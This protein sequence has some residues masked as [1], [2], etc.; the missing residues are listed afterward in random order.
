MSKISIKSPRPTPF[1]LP[2]KKQL[3]VLL[4]GS[5][6]VGQVF[7]LYLIEA[8]VELGF[9]ARPAS[10]DKLKQ[11]L[12]HG[13]IPLFQTSYFRR[14]DP[15][16]HRLENYQVVTDVAESQRFK[17]HQIW[18]TTPSPVY[19]SEW[20]REFLQK[21]PSERVVCFAPEG[22]RS[23]FFPESG[24]EDRLVF[25]GITFISWQ[26]D[27]EGG[28]GRPEGV[29]FWLPPLLGIPL[30]GTEKACREV[31][32]LLKIAGFRVMVKKQDFHKTLASVTAVML[33]FVAGLELSGWS[34]RAF[35][36]SPWLKRAACGSREAVLSQLTGTGIFTRTLLRILFS[37]TGFF[38]ATL[39]LPFLFPFDLEK[40]LKFHYLKTRDQTLTLLDVFARDGKRRGLPVENIQVLLQGLLDSA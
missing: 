15:V 32:E 34:F 29:N 1:E 14:R 4:V 19:Y 27:L 10:A 28:S 31:E 16:A 2:V 25:G 26:G 22:G 7:G 6:A 24:G 35:R 12:E 20:F 37:S 36:K 33:A 17:P 21:V 5:G 9:Y 39:F 38:L 40:Y 11:A 30:I 23:E 8:G 18:F 13:G 3:K